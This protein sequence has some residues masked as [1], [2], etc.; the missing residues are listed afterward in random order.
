MNYLLDT[1]VQ[2]EFTKPQPEHKVLEWMNDQIEQTLFISVLTIGEIQKGIA[3]LPTSRKKTNLELWMKSLVL[4]YDRRII[5]LGLDELKTWGDLC[6]KMA[7]KGVIF[8][9][10]DSL[11]AATALTHKMT[12]VTRNEGEFERTGVKILNIWK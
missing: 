3:A 5:A 7:I 2:S 12:V 8:P 1:C 9:Y 4:R 6:G 10:M 11:I